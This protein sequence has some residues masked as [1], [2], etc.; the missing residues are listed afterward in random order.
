MGDFGLRLDGVTAA[1]NAPAVHAER[2]DFS[3]AAV[4]FERARA[5]YQS[6]YGASHDRTVAAKAKWADAQAKA[7]KGPD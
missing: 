3:R 5:I 6:Y 1:E 7:K 2:Q 4:M